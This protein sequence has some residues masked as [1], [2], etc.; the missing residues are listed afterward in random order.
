LAYRR[1]TAEPTVS[2]LART[3]LSQKRFLLSQMTKVERRQSL[4]VPSAEVSGLARRTD[5]G[6]TGV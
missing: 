1:G 4:L 3:P 5:F 2:A 6:E